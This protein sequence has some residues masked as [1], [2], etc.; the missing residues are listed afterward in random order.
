MK[1]TTIQKGNYDFYSAMRLEQ[2]EEF[3]RLTGFDTGID[4]DILYPYLKDAK[5][6]VELGAGYGRAIDFLL[7]KGFKG[8]VYAV[9]RISRL[10]PYL[11]NRFEDRIQ[12]IQQDI[13]KLDLPQKADAIMWLWSGILELNPTEQ[14]KS[15]NQVYHNLS[16]GGLFAI[17]SPYKTIKVVGKMNEEQKIVLKTEWG[18]LEAY[19]PKEEE[20]RKYAKNAGFSSC[21][22]LHYTSKTGLDRL[23]YLLQK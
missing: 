16:D 12:I 22:T 13:T 9:E 15:V 23:F 20:I 3:A 2:F 1:I 5:T 6:L 4:I 18:E 10:I 19:L 11:K 17:E 21:K 8:D 7:K 14:E